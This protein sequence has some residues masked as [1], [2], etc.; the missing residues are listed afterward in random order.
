LTIAPG[1]TKKAARSHEKIKEKLSL[2]YKNASRLLNLINQLLEF[3][4]IDYE[5]SEL[6]PEYLNI[7]S[8]LRSHYEAFRLSADKK[9]IHYEF[10]T[11]QDEFMVWFDP[12]KMEKIMYNLLS[13]AFKYTPDNGKI[14]VELE[15]GNIDSYVIKIKDSGKGID[16]KNRDKIFNRFNNI[17]GHNDLNQSSGIGLSFTKLLV[18]M[19]GGNISVDSSP[20]TGAC[21]TINRPITLKNPLLPV[22]VPQIPDNFN[23]EIYNTGQNGDIIADEN[24][25]KEAKILIVEDNEELRIFLQEELSAFYDIMVAKDG[26]EGIE[27]TIRELPDLIIS[28][29]MMPLENGYE[30]CRRIKMEWQT[31]NIPVILLTAKSDEQ[32]MFQGIEF[33]A[34]AYMS[35]PFNML[36]LTKQINN[37]IVNRKLLMAKFRKEGSNYLGKELNQGDREFINQV[38]TIIEENLSNNSFNVEVLAEKMNMS[39]SLL[40]KKVYDI[41]K[42]SIGELIRVTRLKK[43]AGLIRENRYNISEVAYMVGFYER[44]AFTRSFNKF[45][46]MNPKQYHTECLKNE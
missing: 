35:K 15:N 31:N 9:K 12:D 16:L 44:P 46:G 20:G 34:D 24:S 17:D 37:L 38:N 21:F 39:R 6:K 23:S 42:I 13:N 32:S 8:V 18:E 14:I 2:V 5:T 1:Y 19:H 22:N 30:L 43:A 41:T 11:E 4:K 40:Y 45:F 10:S 3:R 7:T 28:D 27:M 36:H 33:G 25:L 29:I 26:Q